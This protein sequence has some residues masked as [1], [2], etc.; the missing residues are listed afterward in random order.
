MKKLLSLFCLFALIGVSACGDD[1]LS[2]KKAFSYATSSATQNGVIFATIQNN[3]EEPDTLIG[4]S[5][6]G[7]A[8]ATELHTIEM[9]GAIS[10]MR[11]I[12]KLEIPA[13]TK[14]SLNPSGDHIMLVRITNPLA[15]GTT[16]PLTLTFEKAGTITVDVKV[17]KPGS[18]L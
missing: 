11:E 13:G 16:Y 14:N 6:T 5:T 8:E 18:K 3:T 2:V 9:N 12:E 4:V 10:M 1:T 15:E 17:V 7:I